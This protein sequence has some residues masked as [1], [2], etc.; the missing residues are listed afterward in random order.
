MRKQITF[1]LVISLFFI[2]CKNDN[3]K[4][5]GIG[6][7][8]KGLKVGNWIYEDN[9]KNEITIDWKTYNSAQVKTSLPSNWN[10]VKEKDLLLYVPYSKNNPALYYAVLK[11][12]LS[13]LKISLK[14]YVKE[15]FRQISIKDKKF[16]YFIRRAK[17]DNKNTCYLLEI[18][19]NENG[20]KYKTHILVYQKE[21][22]I[23]DFGY[24]ILDKTSTNYKNHLIFFEILTTFRDGNNLVINTNANIS[25]QSKLM[26]LEDLK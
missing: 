11:Y 15:T 5:Y 7:K 23:Y 2:S 13:E 6:K 19:T 20:I 24:K 22:L 16:K 12:D 18:Y 8:E 10:P 17:I 25:T 3:D 21:N 26:K 9:Q 4:K 1:T 14:D